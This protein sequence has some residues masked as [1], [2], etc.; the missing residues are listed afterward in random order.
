M[1]IPPTDHVVIVGASLAGMRAAETLRERGFDGPITL[2]GDERANPYDRPPL[3]KQ[4][5]SGA[6]EPSRIQLR[7]A[8]EIAG[9]LALEL[10]LGVS[11]L[12]LD[13]GQR[14]VHT[15]VGAVSY[16]RLVIA[17]G[18]RVRRLPGTEAMAHVHV[19]R[20]L[21]DS[22]RLREQLNEGRR[23]VVVGAGFIGAEVAATAKGRGCVVTILEALPTPLAR[24]LGDVMGRACGDLHARNGVTL[25]TAVRIDHIDDDAVVLADGERVAADVVV[26]GI[27]VIPNVEW[28][29]QSGVLV[30]DG[31]RCDE[32]CRVLDGDGRPLGGTV[33]A[34]DVARWP[35]ARFAAL[36]D[37]AAPELM[38]IEHWTNAAD[39]G[40]HAAGTLLGD[41]LAFEPVP[42]FWSDQ[43][44]HKIQFLGRSTGFDE[45]RVVDGDPAD[46]AWLALYR[47]GDRLIGALGVSKTRG[48]MGYHK[49][50]ESRTSWADA[51][52]HAGVA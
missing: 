29:T 47:R 45:V 39:M 19:V 16:D 9:R 44:K 10:R 31:V 52:A 36:D 23:V 46:A 17:T 3:S 35:N 30:D 13:V 26:V 4:L 7:S 37:P 20:T 49:L 11:A 42:Y 38:R 14:T 28:L 5:L 21:D 27:G 33:A 41:D 43:Y 6:W 18:A 51:L 8:E 40:A 1:S 32:R 12:G 15:S 48:L 34:G 2:L 24:Q 50:L 22:L 25:R